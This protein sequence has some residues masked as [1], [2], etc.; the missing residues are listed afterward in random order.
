MQATVDDL[1]QA[2]LVVALN[3]REHR[4]LLEERFS[5][6]MAKNRSFVEFWEVDDIDALDPP[7]ALERI[8]D[9]VDVLCQT[10]ARRDADSRV[11][12]I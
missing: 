2:D 11:T 3:A 12:G 6:W 9:H 1:E 5:C 10:L 7:I 8:R 4:C